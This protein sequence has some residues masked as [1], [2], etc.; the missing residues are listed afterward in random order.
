VTSSSSAHDIDAT[1]VQVQ[2]SSW[3]T[4]SEELPA[5]SRDRDDTHDTR[6]PVLAAVGVD[7]ADY[8]EVLTHSNCSGFRLRV[9]FTFTFT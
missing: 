1:A 6:D 4:H 8:A 3:M 2:S 5:A 9:H 7:I